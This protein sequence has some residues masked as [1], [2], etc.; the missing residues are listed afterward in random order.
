[1]N[2]RASRTG[3]MPT[4]LPDRIFGCSLAALGAGSAMLHAQSAKSYYKQGQA[5]EAREDYD[6]AFMR[7]PEGLFDGS[8]GSERT[9][10]PIT[11]CRFRLR[12]CT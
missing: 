9:S 8:Q 4:H 7:L 5:A 3:R 1:M 6:A 10:K 12:R 11:A 2:R